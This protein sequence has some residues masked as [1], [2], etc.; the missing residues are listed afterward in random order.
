MKNLACNVCCILM[1]IDI[2]RIRLKNIEN[3]IYL[4]CVGARHKKIR[5]DHSWLPEYEVEYIK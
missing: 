5:R 2:R 1:N 3:K 4:L